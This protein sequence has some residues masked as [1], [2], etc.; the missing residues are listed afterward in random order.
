MIRRLGTAETGILVQFT[1][2]LL[3]G[4]SDCVHTF[5]YCLCKSC[6]SPASL[7]G[8]SEKVQ[9]EDTEICER[10]QKGMRSKSFQFGRYAPLVEHLMYDFHCNL[11]RDYKTQLDGQ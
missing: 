7:I 6:C 9:Y 1:Y 5:F 8:Y 10:V 3:V 2:R 11:Y 4:Q